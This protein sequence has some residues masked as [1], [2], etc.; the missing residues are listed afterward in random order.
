MEKSLKSPLNF[1]RQAASFS[2]F[3]SLF[4]KH[5]A[6]AFSVYAGARIRAGRTLVRLQRADKAHKRKNRP[7]LIKIRRDFCNLAVDLPSHTGSSNPVARLQARRLASRR[8][9][10]F[11]TIKDRQKRLGDKFCRWQNFL[12]CGLSQRSASLLTLSTS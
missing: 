11:L 3:A 8:G 6:P 2:L 9:R 7:D 5:L 10:P 12:A 1:E 4:H